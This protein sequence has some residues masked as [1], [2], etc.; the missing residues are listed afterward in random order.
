VEPVGEVPLDVVGV[1]PGSPESDVAGGADEV[2]RL[3]VDAEPVAL[4]QEPSANAAPAAKATA[5]RAQT[6]VI[7]KKTPP[8]KAI[9]DTRTPTFQK[10]SRGF[11]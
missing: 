4:F 11:R 7:R 5:A 2:V 1:G 6:P 3:A 8:T 10:G 9:A